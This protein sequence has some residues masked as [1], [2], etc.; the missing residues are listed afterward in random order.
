M[1]EL[2]TK[3]YIYR[4]RERERE[5]RKREGERKRERDKE[6]ERMKE[7]NRKKEI[8]RK[9]KKETK[10]ERER[11]SDMLQELWQHNL[12][13]SSPT[14]TLARQKVKK[15]SRFNIGH[16]MRLC[17]RER[18]RERSWRSLAAGVNNWICP[19]VEQV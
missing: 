17:H 18:E 3:I 15:K 2:K 13:T 9:R 1:R 19:I 12:A 7:R 11:E 6:R 14:T 8:E 10:R 5:T 16:L 4:E